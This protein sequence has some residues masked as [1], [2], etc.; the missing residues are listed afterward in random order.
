MDETRDMESLKRN[1]SHFFRVLQ[2]DRFRMVKT[3]L[4]IDRDVLE[5]A[6]ADSYRYYAALSCCKPGD[7]ACVTLKTL[8]EYA[9]FFTST[10]SGKSYLLRRDSAIRCLAGYYSVLVLDRAE[11][12]GLNAYGID[13]RPHI[14]LALD[15]VSHQTGL[16]FKDR[17]VETLTGLKEKYAKKY[18][19]LSDVADAPDS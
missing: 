11:E 7:P 14:A 9:G 18:P 13:I 1:Q 12:A 8:Y 19:S 10:L 2:K 3:I 5:Y 6:L 15:A 16:V 17:Y 4:R